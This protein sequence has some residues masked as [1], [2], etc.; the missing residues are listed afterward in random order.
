M[1]RL[2]FLFVVLFASLSAA[3]QH[4]M[5]GSHNAPVTLDPGLGVLHYPVTT[6][7]AE[8]Q[9]YFDQGMRYLYAFNH[10]E[11]AR[12]FRRAIELDPAMPMAYWGLALVL[13][14]NINFDVDPE[15]EA[16][17]YQAVQNAKEHVAAASAKERDLI[18]TLA[19]RYTN[20]PKGDLKKLA[21]DYSAAMGALTKKYPDDL[22]IATLYAESLMDLH[23]WALWRKDGTPEEG[24]EEILRVL[25]SVLA[26][27]PQHVGANH[28]YIHSIEA[29][30]HPERARKSADRLRTLAPAASHLVHMPA[31]IYQRTGNYAGAALANEKAAGLDRAYIERK[32][33]QPFYSMYNAHNLMFGATSH[34]MLGH[35]AEAA[36]LADEMAVKLKGAPPPADAAMSFP[37]LIRTRFGKWID[38]ISMPAPE[39]SAGAFTEAAW[40]FARAEAFAAAGNVP[41]AERERAALDAIIPKLEGVAMFL[42]PLQSIMGIASNVAAGR[43]A[44]AKG[45][46]DAALEFY[47]KAVAGEDALG[48][49]EPPDWFY[50]VRETL[51]G[52]LL[53]AGRFSEAETV[54]R[55]DLAKNPD[56]PRSLYGLATAL[57]KQKKS[58][59]RE[60]AALA[61]LWR[62]AP[63]SARD[64]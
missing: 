44:E 24:T 63:L 58:A 35:Y 27:D 28:Y 12:S 61:R 55:E 39:P 30:P 34:A 29:S 20:D 57:G 6:G 53:R 17:A 5:A 46:R 49:N 32:G 42:N 59:A 1:R 52:A 31:H 45:E 3:A 41:G 50:P 33:V 37:I 48:Y 60:K 43:I 9:K 40:H 14:P 18:E 4:Q 15:R 23:P 56:N 22:N 10:D 38:I 7:S 26:R 16:A 54:F 19:T 2:T 25:E 13:G 8:A 47:R 11:S 51:G 21:R 64:L 36:K 62:G